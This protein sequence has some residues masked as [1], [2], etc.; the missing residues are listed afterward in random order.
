MTRKFSSISVQTTL[1]TGIANTALTVPVA[2]GTGSTLMGGV[3]LAGGNVDQYSLLID[4]NTA[5]AEIMWVTG[6]SGDNLT[7]LRGQDGTSAVS[8]NSGAT[9][10]HVLTGG[11]LAYLIS[12]SAPTS[13]LAAAGL[14]FPGSTSG[15]I[16]VIATPIAGTSILTLPAATDTLVGKA[17][18]DTLTNKTIPFGSNTFTGTA[19]GFTLAYPFENWYINAGAFGGYTAYCQTNNAVHYLTGTST[20]NG[21]LNISYAAGTTLNTAMAIGQSIT[22]SLLIT[23]T[24]A[25]YPNLIQIDGSTVTPKWSGGTAPTAGNAS[26]VDIYQFTILKTA[27]ATFT[28]FAAGPI[29]YV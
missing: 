23:N 24:T 9:I 11:D 20:S 7:V 13:N 6:V 21:T 8:H 3:S 1:A 29:K 17:T 26:A 10:Q 18:T 19:A 14:P 15:T 5:S 16:N 2:V 22:F 28:V 27:A 4:G 25:Y 12:S